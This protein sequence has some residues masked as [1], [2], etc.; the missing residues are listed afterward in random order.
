MECGY[1]EG[2]YLAWLSTK[3]TVLGRMLRSML[4]GL[5]VTDRIG[6]GFWPSVVPSQRCRA[7]RVGMFFER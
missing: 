7:C 3:P 6:S 2:T 5:S 1:V 4:A